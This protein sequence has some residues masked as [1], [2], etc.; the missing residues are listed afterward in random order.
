MKPLLRKYSEELENLERSGNLRSLKKLSDL[1]CKV[2]LSSN[3][4]LG[5]SKKNIP[6]PKG[7]SFGSGS[8]RLLTGNFSEYDLL[9]EE[10]EKLYENSALF[11]NSGYHAN[12]GILSALS[13]KS[14]LILSDKLNHASIIDGIRLSNAEYIRFKHLDYRHLEDILINKRDQYDRVFIV[15]ESV[16]SMD[17][18]EAD[19]SKLV[20]LKKK[21]NC[22]LYLDEAH[23]LGVRG[24]KGLGLAE[25][26]NFIQDI[27]LLVGTF[28]KAMNSIGAFVI[29]DPIIKK[30]LINKMRSLIFTTALPPIVISWNY[31]M[32]RTIV[33]MRM[34]R[35]HL[36]FLADKLRNKLI[37]LGLKTDGSSNIVPVIIGDSQKCVNLADHLQKKGFLVFPIRPPAVPAGTSRLRLS[38]CADMDWEDIQ[39]LPMLI[40]DFCHEN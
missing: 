35:E 4:Y 7:N 38:L 25:E 9:E 1:D 27:D 31:I 8:S 39:D 26:Q 32:L 6:R 5:V 30:Y 14:D 36:T 29:C 37:E 19:L 28:G 18:D 22:F 11:F 16:F 33:K 24:T 10:L 15:S 12:I 2:N 20:E 3:D 21:Y 17:G 23:S 40:K 13:G 34:E